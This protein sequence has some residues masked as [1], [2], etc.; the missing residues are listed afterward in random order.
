MAE[1][2]DDEVIELVPGQ[3]VDIDFE[4]VNLTGIPDDQFTPL[5]D[6]WDDDV[7]LAPDEPAGSPVPPVLAL[8]PPTPKSV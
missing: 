3:L 8:A 1:N 7:R 2:K 6:Q 4:M 5:G